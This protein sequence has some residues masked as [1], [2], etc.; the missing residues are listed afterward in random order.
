MNLLLIQLIHL[1]QQCV[2][3]DKRNMVQCRVL[4]RCFLPPY[5]KDR[6]WEHER[7]RGEGQGNCFIES[8]STWEGFS[9]RTLVQVCTVTYMFAILKFVMMF[10]VTV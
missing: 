7:G 9:T 1:R 4:L 6:E 8:T 5:I 10:E 2:Q 3:S